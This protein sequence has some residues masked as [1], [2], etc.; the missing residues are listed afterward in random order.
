M[1]LERNLAA[2]EAGELS[3]ETLLHRNADAAPIVA[4][5]ERLTAIAA[6]PVPDAGAGWA[7][8]V[9]RLPNRVADLSERRTRR[10]LTRPLLAAAIVVGLTG[11]AAAASPQV[12]SGIARV[13]HGIE[14]VV[15][16]GHVSGRSAVTNPA[17]ASG[18][19]TSTPDPGITPREQIG[20]GQGGGGGQVGDGGGGGDH[21]GQGGGGGQVGDGGGG[22]GQVGDGGG[23]GGQVGD[24]GGGGQVGD[25]GGGGQVGDGGGGGQSDPG[26][27]PAATGGDGQG[28]GGSSG[29]D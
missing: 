2:W 26:D 28:A 29:G 18:S 14:H 7:A 12:R 6:E 21:G 16:G 17:P 9:D 20:G 13:W 4:L 11:V 15:V 25:G 22:G 23:G 19:G 27:S 1:T 24:G 5:F 10:L 3:R 8:L